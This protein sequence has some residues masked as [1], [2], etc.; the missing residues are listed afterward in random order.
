MTKKNKRLL[1]LYRISIIIFCAIIIRIFWIQ[2][3]KGPSYKNK[4]ENQ[5]DYELSTSYYGTIYDR[6]MI[7]L[8]NKE[9]QKYLYVPRY[10]IINDEEYYNQLLKKLNLT[11][12]EINSYLSIQYGR[13]VKLPIEDDINSDD[14]ENSFILQEPKEYSEDNI[15]AHVIGYI[16]QNG[17]GTG[18]KKMYNETLSKGNENKLLLTFDGKNRLIHEE[19]YLQVSENKD[20]I[21]NSIQL[22]V[23]YEIQKIVENSMESRGYQGAV[24]VTDVNSGEILAMTSQPDFNLNDIASSFDSSNSDHMNKAIRFQY[25]PAS[26]FKTVVLLSALENG[27]D[28]NET[29][30]CEGEIFIEEHSYSCHDN[31]IHGELTIKEAYAQSCNTIFIQLAQRVGG[32]KII[33]T[34]KNIGLD[35][36]VDIGLEGEKIGIVPSLDDVRGPGIGNL[37]L[38]Q[39]HVRLTPI[40]INNLTMIIAND[41]IKKD[42]SIIRGYA[43]NTGKPSK[44]FTRDQDQWVIDSIYTNVIK[45]Y[46]EAVIDEG[47]GSNRIDLE[48]YGGAAGKTGTAENNNSNNGLF[49]G[50][51][52]KSNPKYAITVVVENIGQRYSSSTAGTVFNEIVEEINKLEK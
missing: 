33:E 37:A 29:Y 27:I 8:T 28:L 3:I 51:T 46:M 7:P 26:I 39:Q 41:G 5:R 1:V 21:R 19:D 31:I 14:F 17:K 13:I 35:E 12:E 23:D 25:Y 18:I 10:N 38:G 16:L 44:Q 20:V 2:I 42:M 49:T 45:D 30:I 9:I 11:E 4:A 15:L 50:Y 40:Q 36:K 43:T 52:P 48:Q 34:I 32:S 47:T 6:N 22:T 24:I